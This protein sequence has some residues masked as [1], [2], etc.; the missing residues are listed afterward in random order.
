MTGDIGFRYQVGD[1]TSLTDPVDDGGSLKGRITLSG[2]VPRA[3]A[4]HMIH[5]PNI[6]N[7]KSIKV[8]N[9]KE[10]KGH[11]RCNA[12]GLKYIMEKE[13]FDYVIPM[14]GD[15]EDRPEEI[16]NFIE[17][18]EKVGEQS[19][20]GVKDKTIFKDKTISIFGGGDS[21]LDWAIELLILF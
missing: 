9:M 2:P 16:K 8:I 17:L 3:R 1:D 15:G 11:A 7:L 5:A 18:S 14:D 6:E 20:I 4:F 10:N 13:D 19:I 12:T 21:A